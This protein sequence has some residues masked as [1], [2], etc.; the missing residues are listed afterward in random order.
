MLS[1][2]AA[3]ARAALHASVIAVALTAASQVS[4][5]RQAAS[6]DSSIRTALASVTGRAADRN[7]PV[8]AD[9]AAPL[10]RWEGG[11]TGES[12]GR[13]TMMV[14]RIGFPEDLLDPVWP[15]LARLT[16][17]ADRS[18]RSYTSRLHGTVEGD[19]NCM[20]LKGVISEGWEKGAEVRVDCRSERG[21]AAVVRIFP[22]PASR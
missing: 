20:H 17:Q 21:S 5:Q 22:R 10:Y 18:G 3:L 16:V 19:N 12:A 4:A 2:S 1:T 7:A 6:A 13:A 8:A 15:V 14:E 11:V 9:T